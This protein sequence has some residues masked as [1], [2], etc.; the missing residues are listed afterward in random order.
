MTIKIV[1]NDKGNPPGETR[2]RRTA[3]HFRTPRRV[4]ADWLRGVGTSR[5]RAKRD[6]PGEAILGQRG[7]AFALLR[8][9]TDTDAQDRVRDLILQAYAELEAEAAGEGVS[10]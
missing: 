6:I 10:R 3:L 8:P 5:R 1:P 2:G 4:E 9:L 7:K